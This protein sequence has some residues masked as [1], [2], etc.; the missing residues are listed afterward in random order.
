MNT[1]LNP[2]A[3]TGSA[4]FARIADFVLDPALAIPDDALRHTS[5]L[6]IDTLGVA[7]GA[8]RLEVGHIARDYAADFHLATP[9]NTA[10]MLF[11]G[12]IASQPGAAWA[13]ATQIDNLDGHDGLMETKGHIGCAVVPALC[14]LAERSPDLSG[15][16]ALR[17][18]AMSYEFAARAGLALHDTVSDY[19]TSGAWNALGVA[20]L[21]CRLAG[22]DAETLRHAVGIAE[23]HGPRS[24]M[25]RE[26]DNPTMLHD[27]SGMGALVGLNAAFLAGRGFTGAPAITVEAADVAK[28]WDDLGTRWT[29]AENYVKPYPICR[30]AHAA[31][32]AVRQVMDDHGLTHTDIAAIKIRTFD[33]AARLFAE[34]PASTTEAQ[35]SMHFAVAT[36]V[37]YRDLAPRHIEG[38]SLSDPEVAAILP[39]ISVETGEEHNA[40]FPAGRWS[41]VEITLH[42]GRVLASG[43]TPAS[44]GPGAWRSD[45]DVEAKV[46]SFCDGVLSDTRAKAIWALRDGLL[47][48]AKLSDL[49]KLITAPGDA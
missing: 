13:L 19:H 40:R 17:A 38:A 44:G 22:S 12:R 48:G 21:A 6:L 41:D 18:M 37:R 23:Y 32:D 47:D 2:V 10:P 15:P 24:Q 34:M 9:G 36:M 3:E 26:I 5:T 49:T 31:I 46:L 14:A 20:A 35:Y 33:E 42:D 7:A 16:D 29:V 27:G 43:D 45:A 8:T 25:M 30:W 28:F 11:D 4:Q 39:R 1:H